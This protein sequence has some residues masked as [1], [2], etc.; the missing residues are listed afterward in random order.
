[1]MKR[2][3][4]WK[5]DFLNY[6][7][8]LITEI[9]WK[10]LTSEQT[11]TKRKSHIFDQTKHC[12]LTYISTSFTSSY[13]LRHSVSVTRLQIQHGYPDL[14]PMTKIERSKTNQLL[15]IC[16]FGNRR[17]ATVERNPW[18]HSR[19][20]LRISSIWYFHFL[21]LRMRTQ[22]VIGRFGWLQKRVWST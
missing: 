11:Y 22:R 2:K 10:V 7:S 18:L 15:P 3:K 17:Y 16:E 4:K 21:P 1:M 6:L 5:N 20:P 12:T 9:Y 19:K 8:D 14:L 13:P